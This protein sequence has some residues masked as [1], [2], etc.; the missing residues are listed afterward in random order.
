ML[1]SRVARVL[2]LAGVIACLAF[3]LPA[4][5]AHVGTGAV[6]TDPDVAQLQA[7]ALAAPG[8]PGAAG[9]GDP[10]FPLLGNGGYDVRHYDLTFSYDPATDRLDGTMVI[11]A[12]ATQDLS[13]FDLDLQQLDVSAVRVNDNPVAYSRDGQELQITPPNRL[14]KG[15]TFNVAVD[16]G[17]VPQTIVGSPIVF[18]SPY[19][20]LHTDDG[21]FMGDEPNVASTWMPLSDHPSDKAT[22]TFRVT[23]PEGKSVVANG[24][25]V[26]QVTANGKSTFTWDE[27]DQMATYLATADIGNWVLKTGRTPGGIPETVAVDPT[28]I[29]TR[30]DA[31]DFFYNTT[32][33]AT[34][35]WV[36]NFGP[37]PFNSTGAIADN[38][39]Y[40][41]QPLGFSL[42]TQTRP[43][44]SA[45][46]SSS[47]IAHELAHMWFGDSVSVADWRHI[48]LNEGFASYA[49]YLWTEHLGGA[50]PH[51]QFVAEFNSIPATSSFWN[52]VIADPQRD[53][54]FA[55]AVYRRGAMTLQ[56]LRDK[57][58]ADAFF[59]V[60]KTWTAEHRQANGTTAQ[61]IALCERISGQDLGNFFQVWLYMPSKPTSW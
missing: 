61:F 6:A 3:P 29:A 28:I 50:S 34:D 55:R 11:R 42:E 39:T 15:S 8:E 59:Q 41:G 4:A 47:T 31:V 30:P 22:W 54:M 10:Y 49:Q 20:F 58:G 24:R 7:A 40:N 1:R 19:G 5:H 14:G 56:A 36:K 27:P 12:R 2:A 23:V 32:A 18:G 57:I 53:T 44:Y 45:V 43:V 37:Y 9:V 60:L 35:L 13:R 17:G 33:E 26:S 51:D 25:L 38:A 21:A 16:Y 46:R 48:W 52:V